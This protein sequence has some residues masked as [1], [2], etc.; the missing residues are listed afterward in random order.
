MRLIRLLL[1]SG[2][3][4]GWLGYLGYLVATRPRYDD[5]WPLVVSRPQ[6]LASRV[7]VVADLPDPGEAD[8]VDVTVVEVLYPKETSLKSEAKI[9]V[10]H[11]NECHP[12]SRPGGRK[13]PRDWQRAGRYL[14]PQTPVA[15]QPGHYSVTAIPPSPGFTEPGA[16]RIYPDTTETRA[17]YERIAK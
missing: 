17:Q 8:E 16:Y 11:L 5:G 4:L 6:V 7:D 15:N 12:V 3:F 10:S 13:P 1:V 2:V 14:L 9:K